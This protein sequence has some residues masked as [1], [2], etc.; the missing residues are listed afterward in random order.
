M[1]PVVCVQNGASE[2]PVG[3]TKIDV[4]NSGTCELRGIREDDEVSNLEEAKKADLCFTW[5]KSKQLLCHFHVA[6]AQ[7]RWLQAYCNN[8]S[9][10]ERRKPMKAFQRVMYA[11]SLYKLS[12]ATE[13]LLSMPNKQHGQRVQQ[14][15]GR[16]AEW[17]L[18]FCSELTSRGHNN[19]NYADS[20]IR[21]LKNSV[22]P[23]RKAYNAVALVDLVT[24][25]GEAYSK[26]R[27]LDHAYSRVP[28][29]ELL[30]HKLHCEVPREAASRIKLLGSNVY[31]VPIAQPDD[32]RMLQKSYRKYRRRNG[33]SIPSLPKIPGT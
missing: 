12:A 31:E 14:F 8:V 10:D 4:D 26:L 19:N 13:Q 28:A 9:R 23:Q 30:Y 17:V 21:I 11:S 15:S 24:K 20:S 33:V 25:T 7:W 29:Q 18:M 5:P 1:L 16:K 6:Q 3:N 2:A 32:A 22:L 27:L